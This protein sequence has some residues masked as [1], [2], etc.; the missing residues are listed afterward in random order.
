MSD[1]VI[2]VIIPAYNSGEFLTEA[3]QSAL[4]QQYSNIEIIVVNDGSTDNTLD[5]ALGF[6]ERIT[7]V[8]QI[9]S[10]AAS[11]RNNGAKV[12][13][14]EYLAFLDADD[15]WLPDKLALQIEKIRAGF[16]IVYSNRYNF[17]EI[18]D[19][20]LIQTE[21]M[22]LPEGNIWNLLLKGNMITTSSV[23]I[24]KTIFDEFSGFDPA[25]PPCEDWDLWLKCAEI[26]PVGCCLEPLVKYRMHPGGISRNYA[27]MNKMRKLVVQRALGSEKGGNL[28]GHEK[29]FVK[30]GAWSSSGWEASVAGNYCYAFCCYARA[31]SLTPFNY[32]LWYDIARVMAGRV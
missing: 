31:L 6:G 23:I 9:N 30:A 2:S 18:G 20:P 7:L 4:S 11:S 16:P 8:D 24:K 25:L 14:G 27:K 5:L 13:K 3:I 21:I 15:V 19:L 1:I 10:G 22:E 12:A 28:L 32:H 26:Y 29:R 17:G